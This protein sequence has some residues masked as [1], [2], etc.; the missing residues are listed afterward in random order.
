MLFIS[1]SPI[2][3]WTVFLVAVEYFQEESLCMLNIESPL[4]C[5]KSEG[6][7]HDEKKWRSFAFSSSAQSLAAQPNAH[8][9]TAK[10]IKIAQSRIRTIVRIKNG[11]AV[12][13]QIQAGIKM[14]GR[15]SDGSET[16]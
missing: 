7:E 8:S 11:D 15:I 3:S 5:V 10:N 13:S 2:H 14:L 9:G 12:I 16:R 6:G 4:E 1:I